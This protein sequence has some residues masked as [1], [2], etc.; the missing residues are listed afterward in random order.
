VAAHEHHETCEQCGFDGSS[1]SDEELLVALDSLEAPWRELL[2]PSD[3][4]LRER[5]APEVWSALEYAAHSRDVT[6]LHVFGVREA[7]TGNEP[8]FAEIAGDELIAEAAQSY[9]SEE[10]SQ[11]LDELARELHALSE[12][13]R[14]SG[15][16]NWHYA[17]S[18]GAERITV[19]RL[20]EHALHDSSHHL[21][22]VERGLG[23]LRTL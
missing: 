9:D 20:L 23:Q 12:V 10:V 19:R 13:A 7:L 6:A 8:H 2:A 17:L 5:P 15:P 1:Y 21:D 18:I 14:E 16:L 11:V 3:E 4:H 22:D